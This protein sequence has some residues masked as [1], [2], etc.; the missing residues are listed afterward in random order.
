MDAGPGREGRVFGLGVPELVIILAVLTL[1]FGTSRIPRLARALGE[2]AREL[3]AGADAS[4]QT[5]G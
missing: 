1:V 2:A 5:S 3:R 4:D